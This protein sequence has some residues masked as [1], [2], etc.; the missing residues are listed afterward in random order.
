M[1]RRRHRF[2]DLACLLQQLGGHIAGDV[3]VHQVRRGRS[4]FGRDHDRQGLVLDLD[5][6]SRVLGD[7][8]ALR[9]HE[10]DRLTHVAHDL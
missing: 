2:I 9:D 7:V 10:C 8:A 1:R 3:V 4:R 6:V 5:Q